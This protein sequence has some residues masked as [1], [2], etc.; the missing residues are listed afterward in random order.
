MAAMTIY[1]NTPSPYL[2]ANSVIS[3]HPKIIDLVIL[4]AFRFAK[5]GGSLL[6]GLIVPK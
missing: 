2:A 4:D 5:I 6:T 1:M 3:D